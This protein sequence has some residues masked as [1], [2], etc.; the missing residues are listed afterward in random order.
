MGALEG[1]VL[2]LSI[3]QHVFNFQ[4]RPLRLMLPEEAQKRRK[5]KEGRVWN[6]S[7]SGELIFLVDYSVSPFF[8]FLINFF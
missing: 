7:F 8:S 5:V 4:D 2:T 1:G 3:K 6:G